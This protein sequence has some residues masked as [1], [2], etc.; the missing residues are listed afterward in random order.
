M[1]AEDAGV[2]G[3]GECKG[4][5][6]HVFAVS[7][8]KPCTFLSFSACKDGDFCKDLSDSYLI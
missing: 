4:K 6:M 7:Y 5:N 2:V 3:L 8:L 1:R